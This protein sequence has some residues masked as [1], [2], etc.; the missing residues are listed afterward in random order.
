MVSLFQT[1]VDITSTNLYRPL[2]FLLASPLLSGASLA[3][4]GPPEHE[5]LE[6]YAWWV[7]TPPCLCLFCWFPCHCHF[8]HHPQKREMCVLTFEG[9]RKTDTIPHSLLEGLPLYWVREGGLCWLR[10]LNHLAYSSS[11]SCCFLMNS[12][13]GSACPLAP[14]EVVPLEGGLASPVWGPSSQIVKWR[15]KTCHFYTLIPFHFWKEK[16]K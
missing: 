13:I 15:I 8:H 11:S 16:I 4:L 14:L 3:C 9:Y 2:S 10:I 6:E 7:A 5:E 12:S 1:I